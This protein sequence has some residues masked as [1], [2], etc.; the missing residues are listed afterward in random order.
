M[1]TRSVTARLADSPKVRDTVLSAAAA[2]RAK[3]GH[4]ASSVGAPAGGA[5][6]VGASSVGT[7]DIDTRA[8]THSWLLTGPP[9]AGRSTTAVAFAAA[10]VCTD[11]H[12]TGCGQC[13]G[14][15]DAF[16]GS[17]TDIVHIVPQELS[18]SK[19]TVDEVVAQA[20]R[21]P[22]IAP[23]RV[24]II[25]DADRLTPE[26]ADALLKTVEEPPASTV[27]V[28][29]APSTD[30]E[31]FSQ[32]LRSRCRHLYIPAP[33]TAEIVRLLTEEEG[34]TESDARL[35]AATSLHHV[36]RARALVKEPSMQQ[37]RAQVI[38]L[39]ELIFHGD[40][41]FQAV[42][43]LL[44]AVDK[45]AIDSHAEADAEER[46]KLEQALGMGAKGKGAAKALRGTA[47]TLKE[48]ES[49][50]KARSTRRKRDVLD[51]ALVDLAGVYRDALVVKT[52]AGVGLTHPDF[53]G[54]AREIGARV[55]VEG[56]VA[57]Q[58]AIAKCRTHLDQAVTPTIA[59]NG[60]VGAIRRACGVK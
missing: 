39:A 10:L 15:R 45:E 51:L 28:M 56:L 13:Q 47:G 1:I 3:A 41:A 12:E 60:M 38:N 27:I 33:S 6:A 2:A 58:D 18:I 23:W 8:M 34:A 59:F 50:Q 21:L 29:C 54:L 7:T 57:C 52:G 17:H 5:S 14:C 19:K 37:R 30:P 32:T 31:D 25:E 36:G 16:G 46:A 55:S 53:E 22:T 35:A 43:S 9:G 20:A 26:A 49:R 40:Q 42:S 48:L 4:G 44:K 24:I 11:A